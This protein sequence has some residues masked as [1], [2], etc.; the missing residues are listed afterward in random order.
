MLRVKA[1]DLD[2]MGLLFERYNRPLFA[3]FYHMTHKKHVSEDLVQN[4]F[5]RML[6]YRQAFRGDGEFR[7]W[8]YALARNVLH[9]LPKTDRR[10]EA[11]NWSELADEMDGGT[12]ADEHFDQQQQT[13]FLHRTLEALAPEQREILILSRFQE[14]KYEEIGRILEISEGAVKTRV[15]RALAELKKKFFTNE[16]R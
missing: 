9:D 7:T 5:Y 10:Q 14:L 11:T 6:K 12:P 16:R 1:G 15:H 2:K 13:E 4:V 8:M 3:F